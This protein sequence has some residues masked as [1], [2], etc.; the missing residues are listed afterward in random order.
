MLI[1]CDKYGCYV[2]KANNSEGGLKA[3]EARNEALVYDDKTHDQPS[4]TPLENQAKIKKGKREHPS[5]EE[6]QAIIDGKIPGA[7]GDRNTD[8]YKKPTDLGKGEYLKKYKIMGHEGQKCPFGDCKHTTG[9]MEDF[10]THTNTEHP[11]K[12][13]KG[14]YSFMH[15]PKDHPDTKRMRQTESNPEYKRDM[16]GQ[17]RSQDSKK[18]ED[19]SN[20]DGDRH[21]MYNQDTDE[22]GMGKKHTGP[23]GCKCGDPKCKDPKCKKHK[24]EVGT[25][26]GSEENNTADGWSGSGSPYPKKKKSDYHLTQ[27]EW[28]GPKKRK[29]ARKKKAIMTNILTR[30]KNLEF[31]QK[32]RNYDDMSDMGRGGDEFSDRPPG[33]DDSIIEQRWNDWHKKNPD[34]P[35]RMRPKTRGEKWE[36]YYHYNATPAGMKKF[37]K[38]YPDKRELS[39]LPPKKVKPKK[40]AITHVHSRLKNIQTRIEISDFLLRSSETDDREIVEVDGKTTL[41]KK[42]RKEYPYDKQKD[43]EFGGMNTGETEWTEPRDTANSRMNSAQ[44][45]AHNVKENIKRRAELRES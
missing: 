38:G 7:F 6:S 40:A 24:R 18:G 15:Y 27:E 43:G 9:D 17:K 42:K 25:G 14:D 31:M 3:P 10:Q 33:I 2:D 8:M 29:R 4:E 36:E 39:D 19:W 11:L 35:K 20:A 12:H 26:H 45:H 13:G 34:A 32:R 1:K 5:K 28:E 37:P 22:G 30:L 21:G 44:Q 16:A 41:R 23:K